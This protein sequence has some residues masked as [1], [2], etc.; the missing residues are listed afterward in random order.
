[1][2]PLD[3]KAINSGRTVDATDL[4]GLL[5]DVE[6]VKTIRADVQMDAVPVPNLS[7]QPPTTALEP[8]PGEQARWIPLNVLR[9]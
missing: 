8:S 2:A 3:P 9:P 6:Q 5:Q 1:V 7:A 4:P